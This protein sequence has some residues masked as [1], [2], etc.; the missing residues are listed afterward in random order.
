MPFASV[1]L[2]IF[3][4]TFLNCDVGQMNHHIVHLSG[5]LSVFFSA[6]PRKALV[7]LENSEWSVAGHEDVH[8]QVK[9]LAADKEGSVDVLWDNIG[10]TQVDLV[11]GKWRVVRP[12]FDL[13]ELIDE[14]DALA[15]RTG[16]GLHDPCLLR[17]PSEL[18]HENC[19]VTWQH[20]GLWDNVHVNEFAFFVLFSQWVSFFF[21]LPTESFDVFNHWVLSC[22]F[23]MVWKVIQQPILTKI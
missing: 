11:F 20:V 9:F 4:W 7:V 18:L 10:F 21:H 15:L 5:V 1:S 23:K 16:V 8:S 13:G 6:K 3:S 19:I 14:E 12:L 2:V 17:L 22:Q